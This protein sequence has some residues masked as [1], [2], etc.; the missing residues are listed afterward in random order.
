[1]MLKRKI[2]YE[3]AVNFIL[4]DEYK[5]NMILMH[6]DHLEDQDPSSI[7]S[8]KVIQ[9]PNKKLP[10][11]SRRLNSMKQVQKVNN[12]FDEDSIDMGRLR[13]NNSQQHVRSRRSIR[14]LEKNREYQKLKA[15]DKNGRF[16]YKLTKR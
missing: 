3:K 11:G 12:I 1:M 2:P 5:D 16:S 6:Y 13:V 9:R 15:K 7:T 4:N 8:S 10:N 14:D